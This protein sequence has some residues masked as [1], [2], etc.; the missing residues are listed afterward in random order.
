MKIQEWV[1]RFLVL[2][3]ASKEWRVMERKMVR[4]LEEPDHIL[5]FVTEKKTG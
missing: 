1:D 3:L 5:K 2:F 4:I